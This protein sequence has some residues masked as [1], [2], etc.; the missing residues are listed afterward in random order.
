MAIIMKIIGFLGKKATK[1]E[2]AAQHAAP[3]TQVFTNDAGEVVKMM[4]PINRNGKEE[5]A[6]WQKLDDGSTKMSI[7][8]NNGFESIWC[9]KKITREPDGSI[10][11]GDRVTIDKDY[12]KYW[13]YKENTKLI[14]D[15]NQKGVLEHK[16]LTYDKNTGNEYF[17]KHN[18]SQDRIY[19][20]VPLSSSYKDM[21]EAPTKSQNIQHALDGQNNYYKF[22]T[23]STKYSRAVAAK[24]QAAIDA[25]K[26]A[27]AE[28]LAAKEAAEESAAKAAAEL[29][30]KQPR[31][32]IA[33]ALN[34]NI[35][36]LVS[37]E[38]KLADGTIE[39][40]FTDPETGKVLAKTQDFGIL[41]KEWIYGGKA[42]MIYMKQVG[43]NQ[44]YII[45]KKGNYT[46][47]DYLKDLEYHLGKT[48]I[49]EQYY[50]DGDSALKR[51]YSSNQLYP[52]AKGYVT[53][54]DKTAAKNREMYPSLAD[55]I[56]DYPKVNILR[57]N[58][59]H[60]PYINKLPHAKVKANEKVASLSQEAKQN[61]INL[62]GLFQAYKA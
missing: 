2:N 32:N 52:D 45:A 26:K 33:K 39:R 25:A 21:L 43:E 62:D 1:I 23:D 48:H 47:L 34:R 44:P 31:I 19:S 12:T 27:E 60:N 16:E 14:K 30:A 61:L 57:E 8:D 53:V 59:I 49:K 20:N 17:T 42:D 10:M 35:D 55:L 54:F 24:E 15:Y 41:H 46:Q 56:Q 4:R 58:A 36:E 9:T 29:R 22:G 13:C 38:T 3:K 37:K 51:S 6:I 40:T 50:Y 7:A 11:G 28:A 18:A 5:F